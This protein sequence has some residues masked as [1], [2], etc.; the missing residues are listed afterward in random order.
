MVGGMMYAN[1]Y[2]GYIVVYFIIIMKRIVEKIQLW[3]NGLFV[4]L[5]T[6]QE[7]DELMLDV[8]NNPSSFNGGLWQD[9]GH[10]LVWIE[11]EVAKN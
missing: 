8:K 6:A 4:T 7:A 1:T 3:K 10:Y 11:K 9:N 2:K 5:I